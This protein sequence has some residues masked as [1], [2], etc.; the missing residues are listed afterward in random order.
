M[1]DH[2]IARILGRARAMIAR[3]RMCIRNGQREEARKYTGRAERLLSLAAD[4]R[5]VAAVSQFID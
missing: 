2:N 3:A 5:L 4:A 1:K